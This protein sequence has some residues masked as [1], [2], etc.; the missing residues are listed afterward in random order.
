MM[1]MMKKLPFPQVW[2]TVLGLL[3]IWIGVQWLQA[4]WEKITS[5]AWVGSQAGGA[6]AGFLKGSLAQTAGAHPSVLGW[7]ASFIKGVALPN[8][9]LFS[10]LVAISEVVAGLL[11][12]AGFLTPWALLLGVFLNLNYLFAGSA[13]VNPEYLFLELLLLFLLGGTTYFSV[14]RVFHPHFHRTAHHHH[15]SGR[16]GQ[17]A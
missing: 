5:P 2:G 13:G 1:V 7:Y 3:R 9:A 10:H 17:A 11:L 8:A 16:T 15:P 6:V 12:I 4:G 14:D